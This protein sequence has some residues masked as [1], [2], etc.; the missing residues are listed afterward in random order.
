MKHSN[1]VLIT[2]L[3]VG[4]LT[5]CE[6]ENPDKPEGMFATIDECRASTGQAPALGDDCD[7]GFQVA[8]EE[9]EKTAPRYADQRACEDAHGSCAFGAPP[10][11]S[12]N[13]GWFFPYMMGYMLASNALGRS[14]PVYVSRDPARGVRPSY[15]AGGS[16][17]Q[18]GTVLRGTPP[19]IANAPRSTTTSTPSTSRGGF[20]SS[21]SGSSGS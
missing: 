1:S 16:S 21:A 11:A 6:P 2:L 14:T 20:G 19:S 7:K 4:T 9:H 13:S 12:H 10:T 5:A 18:A 3:G 15:V 17:A 8:K